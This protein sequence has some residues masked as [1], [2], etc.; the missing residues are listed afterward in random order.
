LLPLLNTKIE[1]LLQKPD[2]LK[3][4]VRQLAWVQE[5][6]SEAHIE[7]WIVHCLALVTPLTDE[8]IEELAQKCQWSNFL[9][10]KILCGHSAIQTALPELMNEC[11]KSPN[12]IFE[13]FHLLSPEALVVA[14]A[15][16][17]TP[18]ANHATELYLNKIR[19]AGR[20]ELNG[21]DLIRL[22]ISPGPMFKN[23]F[24]ALRRARLDEQITSRAEEESFVKKN[25]I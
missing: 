13:L 12:K 24:S 21:D 8:E 17:D 18:K 3:N 16:S 14:L 10:D 15:Q 11:E 2:F 22:G 1:S 23:I 9:K 4:I 5:R 19:Q 25:F 6:D 20:I 7:R